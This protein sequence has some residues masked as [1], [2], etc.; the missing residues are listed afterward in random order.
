[1]GE[2][3]A[4]PLVARQGTSPTTQIVNIHIQARQI[5]YKILFFNDPT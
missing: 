3:G 2:G 1:V 5:I 4:V